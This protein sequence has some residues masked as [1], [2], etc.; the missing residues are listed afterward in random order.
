MKKVGVVGSINM[1]LVVTTER[2]THPAE[3][4]VGKKFNTFPGGKGSI[5][6]SLPADPI[7]IVL[8]ANGR[9]DIPLN[10]EKLDSMLQAD[11]FLFQLEIL[12]ETAMYAM[13]FTG[14]LDYLT[15]NKTEIA[16][17]TGKKVK[18]MTDIK[19]WRLFYI[20]KESGLSL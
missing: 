11:I 19:K 4:L 5:R 10:D 2:F 16:L 13:S 1:D 12:L 15:P 17:L 18:T 20:K 7:S 6:L 8:G 9:V 3:T 14:I